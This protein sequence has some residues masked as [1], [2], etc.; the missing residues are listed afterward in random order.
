MMA[1]SSSNLAYVDNGNNNFFTPATRNSYVVTSNLVSGQTYYLKVRARDNALHDADTTYT[2]TQNEFVYKFDGD[3]P[4]AISYIKTVPAGYSSVDS[5]TFEW[6]PVSD[7][8]S[9]MGKYQYKREN[10]TDNWTDMSNV[11]DPTT[12]EMIT[13]S[14]QHYKEDD[15]ILDVR[16][17]DKA[18]NTSTITRAL[19]Y[20]A[21]DIPAPTNLQVHLD[22]SQNQSVNRFSFSWDK[23]PTTE[24]QGYYF[25]VNSQPNAQNSTFI[26][27]SDTDNTIQTPYAAFATAQGLNTFW[28]ATKAKGTVGWQGAT[29]VTFSCNTAAPGIPTN[30][31]ITDSSNR[32]TQRWQLTVNWDQPA[33]VTQDFN[34]YIVERSTDGENWQQMQT[35]TVKAVVDTD[36]LNTVTY[37]YR[38]YAKD[39]IGNKSAA[40]T[41]VSMKP[42]GKYTSPPNLIGVVSADVQ[43]TKV[44]VTWSTDRDCDSFVQ[45]GLTDRYGLT[46]GQIDSTGAHS[47]QITGLTPGTVYHYSAI[48]R[49]IDGNIGQSQDQTFKTLDAPSISAVTVSDIRLD[50]AIISWQSS[51]I[52]SSQILYGKGFDYSL[53]AT[54]QSSS[55]VTVHVIKLD[56]LQDSSTYHFKIVSTDVDGNSVTSDDYSFNTLEFPVLSNITIDQLTDMPTSTVRVTWD[57][58][59]PITS[60]VNYTAVGGGTKEVAE[61]TLETKHTMTISNLMDNTS[62]VFS[63]TGRDQY[64]NAPAPN[65]RT[66]KTLFD[67]RPPVISNV[68]T[69]TSVSGYGTDAKTQVIISWESDEAGTSQVEYDFGTF[70]STYQFKTQED[71]TLSFSHVVVLSGLKPS[72][73]YHYRVVS[74]DAS[75]NAGYSDDDTILTEQAS[76]SIL[77]IIVNSLQ[78]SLGWLFGSFGSKG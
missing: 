11:P 52:A 48:W 59:V 15:N 45:L 20:Y 63:V 43:A 47:V 30:V 13:P 67:T 73:S 57:S 70:G 62:Y 72:T 18:G 55:A 12:G 71:A 29:N 4:T 60:V 24:I 17:V 68:T 53:A 40:S 19:Y 16:A 8:I 34:G 77:D 23:A 38:V 49:D 51:T 42:T 5:Y 2:E 14:I 37:Y 10:G 74:R 26:A 75:K 41:I 33:D 50:S 66:L 54:D 28:V 1:T 58:N 44:K 46:Q 21:G 61:S 69:D 56:N 32:D 9:G 35:T 22:Q 65:S 7:A 27:A 6:D 25:S 39:S 76:S 3:P 31:L 78:N 36:L 64:G